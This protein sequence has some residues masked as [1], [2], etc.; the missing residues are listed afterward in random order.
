MMTKGGSGPF[1]D[2]YQQ[3]PVFSYFGETSPVD[4]IDYGGCNYTHM[5]D[6]YH[7]NDNDTFSGVSEYIFPVIKNIVG[8][9][10]GKSPA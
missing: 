1:I 6:Y 3:I 8:S 9:A 7:W 2:I 5:Y 10:F 4:D